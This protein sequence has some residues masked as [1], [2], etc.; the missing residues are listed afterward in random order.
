MGKFID[1]G[2]A[3]GVEKNGH[4]GVKAMKSMALN[5]LDSFKGNVKNA[6]N[7]NA[8]KCN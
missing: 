3:I 4:L 5:M 6:I 1:E 2:A 7:P 8:L